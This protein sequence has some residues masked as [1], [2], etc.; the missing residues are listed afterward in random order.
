[1]TTTAG[2]G[3]V[4]LTGIPIG[5]PGTVGRDLYRTKAGG[6]DYYR[7]YQ[8][9]DNATT[10]Y[11]DNVADASL[12]DLIP[13]INTTSDRPQLPRMQNIPGLAFVSNATLTITSTG[14]AVQVGTTAANANDGDIFTA[15]F[16]LGDGSYTLF[17]HG[18]VQTDAGK[19]DIYVDDVL[20]TSA[21]DWYAASAANNHQSCAIT[22]VG[23]GYHL[24]KIKVNGKNASSSDYTFNI[25]SAVIAAA[26]Y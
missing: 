26:G 12:G 6:S 7:L 1:V 18:R 11:E 14:V 22:V 21:Q 17:I 23:N 8:I 2:A 10:T 3:K 20:Q 16:W 13:L 19:V 15:G 5:P 25:Y 9:M 24:L 4:I